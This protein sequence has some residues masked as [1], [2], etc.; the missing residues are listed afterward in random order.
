MRPFLPFTL[1]TLALSTLL[2]S[3]CGGGDST[4]GV[5]INTQQATL[6]E[7][8]VWQQSIAFGGTPVVINQAQQGQIAV[9]ENSVKYTPHA[10]FYGSD[11]AVIEAGNTQYRFSFT[12]TA[13]NDAPTLRESAL[14]ISLGETIT[15]QL[16]AEDIDGDSVSFRLLAAPAN[17]PISLNSDGSFVIQLTE[18]TLPAAVFSVELDD[19]TTQVSADVNLRPA[20]SSNAD[21]ANYYYFSSHSHLQQAEQR[22]AGINDDI[23]TA[24]GYTALAIGYAQAALPD[25]VERIFAEQLVGQFNRAQAYSDLADAYDV[26][27]ES[28]A[29][30]AARSQALNLFASYVTDNGI[31]NISADDASFLL[32]LVNRQVAAGDSQG[33]EQTRALLALFISTIGGADVPYSTALGRMLTAYRN[34]A[35]NTITE[36]RISRH[37][38][39]QAKAITAIG[40]FAQVVEQTGYQTITQGS[41]AGERAYKL[42]AMYALTAVDYY[43]QVGAH[44]QAKQQLAAALSYYPVTTYDSYYPV[45]PRAYAQTTLADYPA[46]LVTAAESLAILYPEFS[47]P[48]ALESHPILSLLEPSNRYFSR[49][50]DTMVGAKTLTDVLAG[51]SIDDAIATIK[52]QFA[53]SLRDQQIQLSQNTDSS[54]YLGARLLAL[55]HADAAYQAISAGFEL[56]QLPAY[57][58]A[59]GDSPLYLTGTRGCLKF[60]QL[61]QALEA[62]LPNLAETQPS[63]AAAQQCADLAGSYFAEVSADV[64]IAEVIEANLHAVAAYQLVGADNSAL[65]YLASFAEQLPAVITQAGVSAADATQLLHDT[66]LVIAVAQAQSND[67]AQALVTL[68]QAV[69]ELTGADDLFSSA[70][71]L[72]LWIKTAAALGGLEF[73]DDTTMARPSLWYQLRALASVTAFSELTFST[74]EPSSL[75]YADVSAATQALADTVIQ[76]I[77]TELA[78]VSELTQ[79]TIA[80]DL[81]TQLAS[82]RDYEFAASWIQQAPLGA[83]ETIQLQTLL[84]AIQAQQ[85]DFPLSPIANVD[86]DQDGL[87]NFLAVNATAAQLADNLISTDQDADNDGIED[88]IDV[89]PLGQ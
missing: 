68:Q 2:L 49:I 70:E 22:L 5:T 1:S 48:Y 43:L 78:Q 52:A 74:H 42:A 34:Q 33:A 40:Q 30:A 21:K 26:T 81:I 57:A 25:Q 65:N 18:L 82:L 44:A 51:G 37:A 38:D 8:S 16:V 59:N 23:E 45:E 29:A 24:A 19:G 72:S 32:A 20:Y 50:Q 12:V 85:D 58:A 66:Q 71:R 73:N 31:E 76:Q 56:L 84:A 47:D 17:L 7:D 61:F 69:M 28:A 4:D 39:D 36:Y 46:P 80:N 64:S 62:E 67:F 6:A 83:A 75:T 9:S 77:K 53:E 55:G 89:T 11:S 15:G 87:A 27:G 60:V 79:V 86:T 14:S 63:V 3:G 10:N 88:A 35:L 13:V 41:L 54:P